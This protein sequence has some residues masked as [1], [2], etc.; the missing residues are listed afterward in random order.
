MTISK[1]EPGHAGAPAAAFTRSPTDLV[2]EFLKRWSFQ[3]INSCLELLAED[4]AYTLHISETLLPFAGSTNGREAIGGQFQV[5][6]RDWDYLVFRPGAARANVDDPNRVHCQVE[7]IYRHRTTG[8]D[9]S[10]H[11]RLVCKVE[12][13]YLKSVDEYHDAGMVEAF[14]RLMQ[15]EQE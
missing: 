11:M 10:G 13:G 7:F 6:L 4:A 8:S 3:N 9:L 12:D 2:D 15:S 14:L 1:C 5:M